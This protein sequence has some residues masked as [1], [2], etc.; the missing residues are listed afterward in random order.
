MAHIHGIAANVHFRNGIGAGAVIQHQAL[1]GDSRLGAR[2]IGQ[3]GDRAAEVGDAAVPRNGFGGDVG[4][5]VGSSMNHFCTGVQILSGTRK[6][7]AGKLHPGTLAR[8]NAHGVEAG[9]VRA[10]RA[11]HPLDG[12]ALFHLGTLGVQVVHV[13]G[14]VLNGG[15]AHPGVL[16]NVDLHAAC[17]KVGYI[18]FRSGAALNEV[19]VSALVHN[20]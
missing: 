14:P 13:L 12:A 18:I 2:G 10:E 7:D 19:E 9:G 4:A 17:V 11:G 3:H 16:T 15:V 5:G 20:N 8:Q 6:S 1:A